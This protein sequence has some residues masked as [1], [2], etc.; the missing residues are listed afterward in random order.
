MCGPVS[1]GGSL[2]GIHCQGIHGH[3]RRPRSGVSC[4]LPT[5]AGPISRGVTLD[6][7]RSGLAGPVARAT[8]PRQERLSRHPPVGCWRCPALLGRLDLQACPAPASRPGPASVL[9][10]RQIRKSMCCARVVTRLP[11]CAGF[12]FPARWIPPMAT[13]A[14]GN[15]KSHP[16][17]LPCDGPEQLRFGYAIAS[18]APIQT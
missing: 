17:V 11:P 8:S 18:D 6:G 1:G 12:P 16:G 2:R 9:A 7:C 4:Y 15:R 3:W 10:G 5:A 14:P 13:H